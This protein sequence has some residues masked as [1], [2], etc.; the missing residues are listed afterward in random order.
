MSTWYLQTVDCPACGWTQ[1]VRLLKGMHITR[2]PEVQQQIL[3]GTF[4]VFPCQQCDTPFVIERPSIYTDFE[5]GHYIAIEPYGTPHKE[6]I[7]R[8]KRI[9]DENFIFAPDI[10]QSLGKRLNPRIVF[11]LPA[12]REKILLWENG[13][14]DH[15]VEGLKLLVY[16][17]HGLDMDSTI[18]RLIKIYET[19]GHFLFAAYD[20]PTPNQTEKMQLLTTLQPKSWYTVLRLD[21]ETIQSD[22]PKLRQLMP[23]IFTGWSVDISLTQDTLSD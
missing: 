19:G 16:G 9:F 20:K 6:A 13:L 12:L 10:A 14:S 15:V 23:S 7:E 3:N 8:H 2:I 22:L 17:K 4:Q 18:L 21:Y 5:R 11:G 1:Q